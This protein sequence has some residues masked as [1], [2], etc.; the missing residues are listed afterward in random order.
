MLRRL[1]P[2]APLCLGAF[3]LGCPDDAPTTLPS[4]P[5]AIT[6]EGILAD[7]NQ[8]LRTHLL[9][10][11]HTAS[12]F[13]GAELLG[14]L[15]GTSTDAPCIEGEC[16]EVDP[17]ELAGTMA[18]TMAAEVFHLSRVEASSE[19]QV[20]LRFGEE[21]CPAGE[22]G[23]P[24]AGCVEAVSEL[25]PRLVLQSMAEGDVDAR[26]TLG[27]ARNALATFELHRAHLA[28]DLDLGAAK[29]IALNVLPTLDGDTEEVVAALQQ[30]T[31]QGRLRAELAALSGS[32]Y[33]MSV[34]VSSPLLIEADVGGDPLR[35]SVKAAAQLI[36]VEADPA[37][38]RLDVAFSSAGAELS[39]P[40]ALLAGDDE[41]A[42][43]PDVPDCEPEPS[44][45]LE[46]TLTLIA[47][48]A[49]A[50]LHIGSDEAIV[51]EGVHLD[52]A[53]EARLDARRIASLELG[54]A[55]SGS[56]GL[57][58]TDAQDA[59]RIAVTPSARLLMD[60]DLAPLASQGLEI[61]SALVSERLEVKLDGSSPTLDVR[62]DG[63]L[64]VISGR[65]SI[66]SRA[67]NKTLVVNAGQCLVGPEDEPTEEPE[68]P[69]EVL[70]A[71]AC[72]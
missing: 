11:A 8:N 68:H 51:F 10:A 6:V 34:G 53:A 48:P 39:A 27:A 19:T 56:F 1:L 21:L 49:G 44:L 13:E 25:Q 50:R 28:A 70:E 57:T 2:V 15:V 71:G 43:P 36:S 63:Q 64:E 69:L 16:T 55:P 30:A 18:D 12:A 45:D 14:E 29:A 46:G 61:P 66:D 7:A 26:L 24:E 23:A 33:R 52:G 17:V 42:C 40:L 41:V 3:L 54:A 20:T 38:P 5:R 72:R 37:A 47:P 22:D 65:L 62:E 60:L 4:G 32:A 58:L 9:G 67:A 35:L 31:V 59:L